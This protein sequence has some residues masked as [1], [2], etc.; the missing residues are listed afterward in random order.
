[1][2]LSADSKTANEEVQGDI[3]S[4]SFAATEAQSKISFEI[5][6]RNVNDKRAARVQKYSYLKSMNTELRKSPK[7]CHPRAG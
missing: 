2:A 6:L 4:V 5:R 1:M 3:A 7:S